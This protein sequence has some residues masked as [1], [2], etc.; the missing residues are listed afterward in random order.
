MGLIV[1]RLGQRAHDPPGEA[2][3]AGLH[4]EAVHVVRPVVLVLD[5]HGD[6]VLQRLGLQLVEL[7]RAPRR[8]PDRLGAPRQP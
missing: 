3:A 2:L 1:E 8:S 7:I 5:E 6:Q 4:Q